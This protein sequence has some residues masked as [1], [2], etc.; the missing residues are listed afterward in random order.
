MKIEYT[1]VFLHPKNLQKFESIDIMYD[2]P[3]DE[4]WINYIFHYKDISLLKQI[5][6]IHIFY[7]KIV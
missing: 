4:Y 2:L 7:L 5:I 6:K 1:E 3:H